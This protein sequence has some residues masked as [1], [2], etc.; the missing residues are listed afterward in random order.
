MLVSKLASAVQ[1]AGSLDDALPLRLGPA[2]IRRP[3]IKGGSMLR[4]GND[5]YWRC[6]RSEG[7]VLALHRTQEA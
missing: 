4:H 5:D 2:P 3:E 6:L 1:L 7:P